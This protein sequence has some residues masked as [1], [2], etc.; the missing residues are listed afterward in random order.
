MPKNF[1]NILSVVFIFFE[2]THTTLQFLK[3]YYLV[4]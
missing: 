3:E 2:A 4:Q 1:L